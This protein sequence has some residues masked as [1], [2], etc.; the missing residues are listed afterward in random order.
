MER[1]LDV[2]FC[3]RPEC[4]QAPSRFP[5]AVPLC[6]WWVSLS[7][8]GAV[9]LRIFISSDHGIN[10]PS[11]APFSCGLMLKHL[12]KALCGVVRWTV[13]QES[14]E[15]RDVRSESESQGLA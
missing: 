5:C 1:S 8:G 9:W 2:P 10:A 4:R 12:A 6:F 7:A 11:K 14:R 3:I 15:W 13:R